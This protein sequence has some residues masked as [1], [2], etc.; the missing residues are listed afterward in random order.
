MR[1]SIAALFTFAI[2][3]HQ[4][5]ADENW[6]RFR[7]PN[8]A[9]VA[10]GVSFP[11]VWTADDYVWQKTLPGKGHSSPVGWGDVL[12]VTAGDPASGELALTALDA[13]SGDTLWVRRFKSTP[14]H[15]HAANS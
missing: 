14:H 4:A 3:T 5:A 7:G 13:T 8:G 9:G 15:L 12:F 2:L 6:S 10:S 1:R 11:A